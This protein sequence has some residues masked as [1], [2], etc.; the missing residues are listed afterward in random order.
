MPAMELYTGYFYRIIDKSRRD[1]AL[2]DDL[3]IRILS[4][5]HGLLDPTDEI[6]PYDR[7]MTALRAAQLRE[8]VLPSLI[9]TVSE[10]NV[11]HVVINAAAEYRAAIEGLESRL[12]SNVDV[13]Y[14]TGRGN[15]EMGSKLKSFIRADERSEIPA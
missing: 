5:E 9:K 15:G 4:A 12:N 3:H 8:S 13:S 14:I 2:R 7:R 1:D 10:L 6:C 11:D